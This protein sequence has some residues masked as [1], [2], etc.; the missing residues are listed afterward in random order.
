M[1]QWAKAQRSNRNPLKTNGSI[2]QVRSIKAPP[3]VKGFD[4]LT[5]A[6]PASNNPVAACQYIYQPTKRIRELKRV[7]PRAP[8]P[9][10]Q[11]KIASFGPRRKKGGNPPRV[12]K[13]ERKARLNAL[14][15]L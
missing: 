2:R 15:Y 1:A 7:E 5:P 8:N 10:N 11:E 6:P 12:D 3:L 4:L 14:E 9:T 13:R